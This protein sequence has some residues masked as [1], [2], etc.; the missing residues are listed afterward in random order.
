MAAVICS[1]EKEG[2]WP[3]AAVICSLEKE[4]NWPVAFCYF[5]V[6]EAEIYSESGQWPS[7][8][9]VVWQETFLGKWLVASCYFVVVCVCVCG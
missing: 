6:W 8:I 4:G 1:L 9:F 3:V 5:V 7:V 2:N